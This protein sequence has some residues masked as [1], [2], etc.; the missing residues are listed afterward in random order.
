MTNLRRPLARLLAGTASLAAATVAA[1]QP[2]VPGAFVSVYQ[3]QWAGTPA[4]RSCDGGNASGFVSESGPVSASG[5][6]TCTIGALTASGAASAVR[7][8]ALKARTTVTGQL[9][10][11]AALTADALG[12]YV[13]RVTITGP[14]TPA[15]VV[16]S[17]SI[18]G[19]GTGIGGGPGWSND[20]PQVNGQPIAGRL[21]F[22]VFRPDAQ[23]APTTFVPFADLV[24]FGDGSTRQ[25]E[26]VVPWSEF[27]ADGGFVFKTILVAL[28][29]LSAG[30]AGANVAFDADFSQTAALGPV[31]VLDAAGNDVTAR[32]QIR[33][34]VSAVPEP[35]TIV[36]LA[37]GLA[38]VAGLT[39]LARRRRTGAA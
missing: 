2:P 23:G 18:H 13:E 12:G 1:A 33:F 8:G 14:L 37:T 31:R 16:F 15:S 11:G 24:H 25:G 5:G 26:W 7:G 19:T 32:M 30:G 4:A 27:A 36:L 35:G 9:G 10:A 21:E 3:F 29:R 28:G 20:N 22:G 17:G 39:G 34:G 6:V 38:G